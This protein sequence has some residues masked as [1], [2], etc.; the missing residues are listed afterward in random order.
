MTFHHGIFREHFSVI[1]SIVYAV[2]VF[3]IGFIFYVGDVF[4]DSRG[5]QYWTEVPAIHTLKIGMKCQQQLLFSSISTY[6]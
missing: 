6:F 1:S 5:P 2:G 4:V 3:I